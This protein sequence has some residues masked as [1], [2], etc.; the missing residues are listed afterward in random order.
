MT[1][2]NKMKPNETETIII[3]LIIMIEAVVDIVFVATT[4][5]VLT[6]RILLWSIH[7][8]SKFSEL[9]SRLKWT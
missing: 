4:I 6:I 3:T 5:V 1:N 9:K 2:T 8:T 7:T